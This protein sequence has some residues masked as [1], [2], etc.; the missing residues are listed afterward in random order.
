LIRRCLAA[1]IHSI[2]RDVD[3]AQVQSAKVY[4]DGRCLRGHF[5]ATQPRR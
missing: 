2:G 4:L 1:G 5:A 3:F